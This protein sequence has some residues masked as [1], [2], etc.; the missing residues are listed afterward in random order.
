[1]RGIGL[2]YKFDAIET[3]S[4]DKIL[5]ALKAAYTNDVQTRKDSIWSVVS[6]VKRFP[7][8]RKLAVS[9]PLLEHRGGT[10]FKFLRFMFFYRYMRC[11]HHVDSHL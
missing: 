10:I 6:T 7:S 9:Y 8:D 3:G 4:L 1:M 5:T 2:G 11:Y